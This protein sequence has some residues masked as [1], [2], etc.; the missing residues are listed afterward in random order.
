MSL[1]YSFKLELKRLKRGLKKLQLAQLKNPSSRQEEA[2][3]LKEQQ[4]EV[5]EDHIRQ[6]KDPGVRIT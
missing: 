1:H 5:L 6:G 4:I 3:K 2:I